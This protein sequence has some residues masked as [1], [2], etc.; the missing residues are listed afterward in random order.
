[1]KSRTL[2]VTVGLV[3]HSLVALH[4]ISFD[5]VLTVKTPTVDGCVA[6]EDVTSMMLFSSHSRGSSVSQMTFI[7]SGVLASDWR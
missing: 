5:I 7:Q 1:V 2:V 6:T 4:L 3:L